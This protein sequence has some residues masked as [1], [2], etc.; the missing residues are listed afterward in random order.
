M[1]IKNRYLSPITCKTLGIP[2][3]LLP[4][5]SIDST[6][7]VINA[8]D[9]QLIC[10]HAHD[11]PALAMRRKGHGV[12]AF[13]VP[14]P[15]DPDVAEDRNGPVRRWD[16]AERVLEQRCVDELVPGEQYEHAEGQH[17]DCDACHGS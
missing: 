2:G 15:G 17:G 11:T 4:A 12:V 3:M 1:E 13:L 6:N 14:L 10:S 16:V 8:V 5:S 9:S 7:A